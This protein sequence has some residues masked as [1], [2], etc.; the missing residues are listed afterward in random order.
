MGGVLSPAG[1]KR[2]AEK[3]EGTGGEEEPAFSCAGC[4]LLF[5]GRL[6][7]WQGDQRRCGAGVSWWVHG[8]SVRP[9]AQSLPQ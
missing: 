5:L 8:A 2:L 9:Q 4:S 1:L 7:F 6:W 3:L